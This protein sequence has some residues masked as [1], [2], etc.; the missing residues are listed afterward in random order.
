[1]AIKVKFPN[2]NFKV[3]SNI[4][5]IKAG[6]LLKKLGLLK[7]EYIIVKNEQVIT[8]ED[9]IVDGDEII[10]YAVVSGG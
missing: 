4:N 5:R 10:L 8:D 9:I 7:E 6:E 3:I 1:M 2:G